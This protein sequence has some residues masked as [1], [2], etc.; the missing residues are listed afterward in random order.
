MEN[1]DETLK[2]FCGLS[3]YKRENEQAI[4]ARGQS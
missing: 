3:F 4:T 1:K 2:T